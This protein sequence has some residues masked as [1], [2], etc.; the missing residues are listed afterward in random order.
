M[1]Q[2]TKKAVETKKK[3]WTSKM[4]MS[5]QNCSCYNQYNFIYIQNLIYNKIYT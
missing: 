2:K 1:T 4:E 3:L 5:N